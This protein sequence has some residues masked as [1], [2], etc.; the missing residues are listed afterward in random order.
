MFAMQLRPPQAFIRPA[1]RIRDG[2]GLLCLGNPATSTKNTSQDLLL[3]A[4]LLVCL[5]F[6]NN[7]DHIKM[8]I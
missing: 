7:A 8:F 1:N 2:K 6:G 3:L 5:M 4:P